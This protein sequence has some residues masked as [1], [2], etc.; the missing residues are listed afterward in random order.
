MEG[1][2]STLSTLLLLAALAAP[3]DAVLVEFSSSQCGACRLM[4]PTV[5]RL[6]SAGYPVQKINLDQ[7]P[8]YGQQFKIQGVP[9]YV[10][11]VKGRE[12]DR[13]VGAASYDKLVQLF[14]G[15]GPAPGASPRGDET[16]VRGQS[17]QPE[18]PA[19]LSPTPTNAS[20]ATQPAAQTSYQVAADAGTSNAAMERAMAA[21]VR[22]KV[23][24]ATGIGCG[25]GTI[26]D[27]HESEALIV[28]CGHLF[29]ASQGKGKIMVELFAPGATGPL[30]G[31]LLTYDLDRDI[32]LLSVRPGI[33]ITPAQVGPEGYSVRPRDA[34]FSI[35]CDKGADPTVRPSQLTAV[36]KFQGP[37]NFTVAGQPVDGRSGGGL[38]SAEGYLIGICNAADP[39]DD[40]GLYAALGS[41][42]WQ[43]DQMQ[44]S[45]I[46]RRAA[47]T[48]LAPAAAASP[49][50]ERSSAA[51]SPA[52]V[53]S[54]PP[55]FDVATHAADVPNMPAQM[56]GVG[57]VAG[58]A[59]GLSATGDDD[60]EIIV[61]V[62]SRRN[63]QTPSQ[64]YTLDGVP[65]E[66]LAQLAAASRPHVA[67]LVPRSASAAQ[68]LGEPAVVRGQSGE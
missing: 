1:T 14:G 6:A 42:H 8:Q 27:V 21:T 38:F 29:R 49:T 45:E 36:N 65:P 13:L 11:I 67:P 57:T 32:A 54:Q 58:L 61:I 55:R 51:L 59:A 3:D 2:M 4:E 25:T 24:D 17:P 19:L 7:Q 48:Q 20:P 56:P 63:A 16:L 30:E 68:Y 37:P 43:L 60:T 18:F 39:Q 52:S 10:M 47:K 40:E 62:R 53:P 22:L 9:T 15:V 23:E 34:V 31:Q 66:L 64:V 12:T 28:T 35:G 5:A 44:L 26:I 50:F 46:H 33:A 41:I